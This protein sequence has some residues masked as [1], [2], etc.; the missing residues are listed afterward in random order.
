ML[1]ASRLVQ[2]SS[3]KTRHFHDFAYNSK[4]LRTSLQ[5]ASKEAIVVRRLN[6]PL[7]LPYRAALVVSD[8]KGGGGISLKIVMAYLPGASLMEILRARR[9]AG[10][11]ERSVR[12]VVAQVVAALHHVHQSGY[13]Y[14]VCMA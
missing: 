3:D 7:I 5:R 13:V 4:Q 11:P 10:L 8:P 1:S 12:A 2:L 14:V 9:G 6:H